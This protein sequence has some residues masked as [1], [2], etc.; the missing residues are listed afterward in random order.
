MCGDFMTP[1]RHRH[2]VRCEFQTFR[3]VSDPNILSSVYSPYLFEQIR[4]PC[5]CENLVIPIEEEDSS[6]ASVMADSERIYSRQSKNRNNGLS[7]RSNQKKSQF[8]Q[9]SVVSVQ[10]KKKYG[11]HLKVRKVT[12]DFVVHSTGSVSSNT[13]PQHNIKITNIGQRIAR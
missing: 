11:I 12:G 4:S 6:W 10:P 2:S 7:H 3:N 9:G 8:S 1:T 5:W 13:K